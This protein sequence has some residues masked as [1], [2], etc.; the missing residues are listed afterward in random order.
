MPSFKYS[1]IGSDGRTVRGSLDASDQTALVE[2]LRKRSL[3]PLRV[4]EKGRAL[5]ARPGAG[6]GKAQTNPKRKIT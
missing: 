5:G 6:G 2:E 3:T 1:A 4:E